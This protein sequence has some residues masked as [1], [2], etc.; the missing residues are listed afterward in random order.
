M[1]TTEVFWINPKPLLAPKSSK[2]LLP[3]QVAQSMKE[4]GGMSRERAS[5]DKSGQMAADTRVTGLTI[6][7]M[8]LASY[9]MPMETSTRANGKTTKLMAR[10]LILM[11]MVLVIKGIGET[12]SSTASVSRHGLMELSMKDNTLRAKRMA[13]ANLRLLMAL[14]T[15]AT[16]K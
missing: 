15:T 4:N 6:R 9:S 1:S 8:A 3:C 14:S 12:I 5:A 13:R 2:V 10:V 16:S 7:R 11:Q